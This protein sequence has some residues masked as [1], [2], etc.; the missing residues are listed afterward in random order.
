MN[1][2]QK[3]TTENRNQYL[4]YLIDPSFQGINIIFVLFFENNTH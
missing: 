3:T 2:N 1:I 4:D